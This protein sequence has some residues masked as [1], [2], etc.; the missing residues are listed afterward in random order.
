MLLQ[1]LKQNIKSLSPIP[2]VDSV[3]SSSGKRIPQNHQY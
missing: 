2:D 3:L 1:K